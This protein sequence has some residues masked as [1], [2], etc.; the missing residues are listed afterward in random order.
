MRINLRSLLI[1]AFVFSGAAALIYEITWIRPLQFVFGSTVYTISIIFAAFMGGLALGSL[2]ISKYIDKLKNLPKTYALFEIGIGIYGVLLLSI[3]NLLPGIYN[4]LYF[5]HTNFYLF[6]F[7][8][9][10][11]VFLVLLIPTTL[12][13]ATFPVIAKFYT[14][15]KIGKAIGEVYSA[16]NVGAIIGSFAAGFILIP[17]IGIK[18]SIIFAGSINMLIGSIIILKSKSFE[19]NRDK[20]FIITSVLLFLILAYIGNYSIQQMHSGGFYRTLEIEKDLGPVIYY[21]E[22]LYATVSV[23]E[24][25]GKGKALFINGKGQGS[26]GIFDLRVNFMLAYLPIL[27]K[28][29]TKDVLVIGLGTGTTSGQ[30]AQSVNVKTIEIES[31]VLEGSKYFSTFNLNVLENPNHTLIIDDGRNWLLKNEEKYDVIIPE[32]SDPWQSFST[33]L[34]SKEF[35][36]LASEDLDEN[37]LYVQWVP[38]YQMSV[39][40]FKNFYKTFT[41]VFPNVVVFANIKPDEDT[42]VRFETSELIFVGSK[43]KINIS[44]ELINENYN[45][46]P[47]ISKQQLNLIRLSSGSEIYHLFVFKSEQM[48]G[49]AD[50]AKIITDDNLLLEFST[51]KRVLNQGPKEVINDIERFVSE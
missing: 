38:I 6:E 20:I 34:F 3:F 5:L 47:E 33:A 48:K 44:E 8:Q 12:M 43:N 27:L 37:G 23:R 2:I 21:N 30:L 39:K 50:D 11:I 31:A 10:L 29:D 32:H 26:T 22:G 28:P 13:G 16:N 42:P 40:D 41:S 7:V 51:A 36:E 45:K 25:F 19:E 9:F 24:L 14:K 18:E 15:E 17:L 46:L 1:I 35:L 4:S 49:Y